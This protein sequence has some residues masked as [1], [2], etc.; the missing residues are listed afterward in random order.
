MKKPPDVLKGRKASEVFQEY[1]HPYLQLYV[2]ENPRATAEELEK[3][4]IAPWTV[5]NAVVMQEKNSNVDFI[6]GVRLMMSAMPAEPQILIE[7]MIERKLKAFA[8]YRYAIGE[9]MFRNFKSLSVKILSPALIHHF[10]KFSRS[11]H[12]S[13]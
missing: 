4:L 7:S 5:W 3:C 9:F 10:Q 1:A 2:E 11:A 13:V 8:E 6:A 12:F